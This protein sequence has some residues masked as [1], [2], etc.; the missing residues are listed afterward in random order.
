M[1][2]YEYECSEC[3]HEFEIMHSMSQN[4]LKKCPSCKKKKLVR[5]ISGGGAV[6]IKGTQNPCRGGRSLEEKKEERA[7]R[8][9]EK[10]KA[11]Q[12]ASADLEKNPPWWRSSK[13]GKVKKNILKNPEKYIKTGEVD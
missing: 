9:K 1:V 3:G 6:I 7:Y 10:Q 8:R 11:K 13:D 4:P 12:K 2:T 5:L